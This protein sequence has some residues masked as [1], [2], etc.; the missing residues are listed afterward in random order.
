M[1][2][3]N[4]KEKAKLKKKIDAS[5]IEAVKAISASEIEAVG[6]FPASKTEAMNELCKCRLNPCQMGE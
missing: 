2:Q 1:R 5:E 4:G 6:Y 3:C